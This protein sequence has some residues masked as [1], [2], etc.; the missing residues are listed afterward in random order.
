MRRGYDRT[1][2][3]HFPL[4]STTHSLSPHSS[5]YLH[6][7]QLFILSSFPPLTKPWIILPPPSGI[8]PVLLLVSPKFK[9]T[10]FSLS[11]RSSS[12]TPTHLL[13]VPIQ[14]LTTVSTLPRSAIY[15]PPH[16]PPRLATRVAQAR[17]AQPII[18]LR[19]VASQ[20][21]APQ[22]RTVT[23]SN[24]RQVQISWRRRAQ[25]KSL[26]RRPL[27]PDGSHA[28]NEALLL[29]AKKSSARRKSGT[30]QVSAASHSYNSHM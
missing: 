17:P 27:S 23:N 14:Y 8:S 3:Y 20:P 9:T 4:Y 26:V 15:Q 12:T 22:S 28:P 18:Q 30:S 10:T 6:F 29:S 2:C 13:P 19:P 24:A 7:P 11:S 25:V 5:L 1:G 21:I 16:H